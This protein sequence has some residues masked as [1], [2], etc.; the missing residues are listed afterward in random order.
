MPRPP[1]DNT[2]VKTVEDMWS[3]DPS[4]SAA[5]VSRSVR[6]KLGIGVISPRKVQQI[7][8]DV[9]ARGGGRPLKRVEWRP[10]DN[11]S[12]TPEDIAHLLKL[13][14]I[15]LAN[16]G[17]H[18]YVHEAKW[19]SRL[20]V[21][22]EG[23]SP[24]Q[25]YLF[26]RAYSGSEEAAFFLQKPID[27][28][29]LDSIVAYKPWLSENRQA[30]EYAVN[31]GNIPVPLEN[32]T[33]KEPV[34]TVF[35]EFLENHPD[36]VTPEAQEWVDE[37]NKSL[38]EKPGYWGLA[39]NKLEFPHLRQPEHIDIEQNLLDKFMLAEILGHWAGEPVK[40]LEDHINETKEE[41]I[42]NTEAGEENEGFDQT[43]EQG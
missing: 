13:D 40:S 23:L 35:R 33:V 5:Q 26:I 29:G 14:A 10:W 30:Y 19:G 25:Q 27:T 20:R 42:K 43:Q 34:S 32:R 3:K 17:H 6:Q 36:F 31:S 37:R 8:A 4:Q 1:I 2:V 18:L 39:L 24:W 7:I 15:S 38:G 28:W 11:E 16:R 41:I 22:L 9:K 21:A 12:E